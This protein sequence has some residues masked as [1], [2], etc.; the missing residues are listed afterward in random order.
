[1]SSSRDTRW[2]DVALKAVLLLVVVAVGYLAYTVLTG[3]SRDKETATASTTI[4]DLIASIKEDPNDLGLRLQLAEAYGAVGQFDESVEQFEVVLQLD[5]DNPDALTGLGLIAMFEGEWESAEGY[6]RSVIDE[7]GGGQYAGVDQRL[8]VAYHQLGATLIERERYREATKYLDEALRIR[9]H[10][11]DTHYALA[12]AHRQ[13][14]EAGRQRTHLKDALMFDPVMP[15]ANYDYGLLLLADGDVAGAAEH[16]RTSADN[17]PEGHDEP[18]DELAGLGPFEDRLAAATRLAKHDPVGA[19]V[20][21]RVARALDPGSLEA[22][23]LVARL[24][25]RTGD[26]TAAREAWQRVLVA[27]PGETEAE[28]ALEQLEPQD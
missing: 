11:S 19:L 10:A 2:L 24:Y 5:E 12:V 8:A 20:E 4:G 9:P 26:T 15:E 6:W 21:A 3:Q 25:Q 14:G 16:F 1:M 18:K 13:L 27:W 22:A 17:A 28:R 7:I 23:K